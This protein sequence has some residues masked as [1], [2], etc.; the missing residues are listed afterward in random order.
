MLLDDVRY[1][2]N[3][4]QLDVE[5]VVTAP[6]HIA[7]E[8][9]VLRS[10]RFYLEVAAAGALWG[11]SFALD[12]TMRSHLHEMSSSDANLLQDVSY[13]SIGAG[14]ALT[15]A[16]GLAYQDP[17]V[18]QSM[19]TAGEAAGVATLA[20]EVIIKPAFGRLRPYQ[21]GQSHTAFFRGGAS[22]VSSDVVPLFSLATGISHAFDDAW[23]VAAPAYSLA[24]L[25]GFGRMGH[26]AHWFSDV[27]GAGLL[28]WGTTKL[29]EHLH[30]KH[31]A[32]PNRWRIMP[33]V[34]PAQATPGQGVT[35]G[36]N[37]SRVW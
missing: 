23:Y 32:E 28:G 25:D 3:N 34:T 33:V 26:D 14:S 5:D 12:Q 18:R 2:V 22:F 4:V 19:L 35:V 1:L 8:D 15:Y 21:D 37:L 9:S 6:L 20:D 30:R 11:V 7:D 31:E 13:L 24:L 36:I 10:P 17:H 16:Y 29:F 27:V